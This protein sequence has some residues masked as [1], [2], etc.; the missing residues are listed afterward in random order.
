MICDQL[1]I[2]QV[3][4]PLREYTLSAIKHQLRNDHLLQRSPLSWASHCRRKHESLDRFWLHCGLP[5][6]SEP[7][8]SQSVLEDVLQR[9]LKEADRFKTWPQLRK[10]LNVFPDSRPNSDH[11]STALYAAQLIQIVLEQTKGNQPLGLAAF[12][13]ER[14]QDLP[15]LPVS[16]LEELVFLPQQDTI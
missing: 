16:H 9:V 5:H 7:Y 11:L 1:Q 8:N 14:G 3:V 12:S 10:R 2:V 15:M 13:A 6:C 4:R